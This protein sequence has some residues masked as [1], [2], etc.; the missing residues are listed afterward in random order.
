VLGLGVVGLWIYINLVFQGIIKGSGR[1]VI[2][3]RLAFFLWI[4]VLVMGIYLY[5]V[6]WVL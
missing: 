2:S 4:I 3:M 6:T 5:L 1:P